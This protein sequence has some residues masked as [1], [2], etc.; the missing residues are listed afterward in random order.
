MY[1]EG[2]DPP[3]STGPLPTIHIDTVK[4]RLQLLRGIPAEFLPVIS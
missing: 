4:R 2:I 1:T 3:L